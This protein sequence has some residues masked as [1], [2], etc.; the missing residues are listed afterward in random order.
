MRRDGDEVL[1]HW[2][3]IG[4]WW[5]RES[6]LE[7]RRFVDS[8][9][10][11]REEHNA[12][13]YRREARTLERLSQMMRVRDEKV[14]KAMGY[15]PEP[16][17]QSFKHDDVDPEPY[18]LLFAQSGCAFGRSTMAVQDIFS[19]AET[20]SYEATLLADPFS[21]VGAVEFAK[22]ARELER[23]P[24]IGAAFEM[25]EGGEIVLVAQTK[26]GYRSLSRLITACHQDEPRLYPLCTWERLER[27]CEDLL[28]LTGGDN[29]PINR[30]ITKDCVDDGEA[31]L[32]RFIGLYGAHKVFVQ[33]ER[34][35][36]PWE[37]RTNRIL[38]DLAESRKLTAV[39]GNGVTHHN[40]ADF[41]AQD[42]L[43]CIETLCGIEEIVG[44]KPL[45]TLG[46]PPIVERPRRALNAERYLR[47]ASQMREIFAD[48]P[49]LLNNTKRLSD[50]CDGHVLPTRTQLPQFDENEAGKLCS[51]VRE[52][53][54]GLPRWLS[55]STLPRKWQLE[56]E[57]KRIIDRGFAGHFLVAWDMCRWAKSQGIVFSGRGSVVDSAVAYCLGLSRI[58]AYEHDLHFDRFL[59]PEDDSKRPDID[60]D[61]EARR[62]DDVRNYLV[63]KYGP[64]HVATV[65]AIGTFNTRGIVREVG[66]VLGIPPDDLSY[67]AKRIH[68]SVSP[69]RIEAAIEAKPELRNSNIPRERFHLVFELAKVL[70]DIPRNL[71]AHSSGV[72]ISRAPIADTVPVVPSAVDGIQILQWDKRSAKHYFDKF[73]ILCLRG[74]D[75][76]SDAMD[77]IQAHTPDF[78]VFNLPLDDENVYRTMRTGELI[79]VP[80]SA[81]PAM[82]QAHIRIKTKNLKEA[83]LVQAG[84]RPGVGGAVKLNELILRKNGKKPVPDTHPLLQKILGNTY[85]L[86]VFQE[87]VDMLLQEFGGYTAGQAEEIREDIYKK[88]REKD[89]QRIHDEVL[90]QFLERGHSP[91]VAEQV[92]SLVAQFQGYGFAE[93]HALA[94]AEIS[95]RSIYCQQNYP[96]EYFAA[97]LDA[98][99]A[100]YYG[101]CTLVNEARNRGVV[102]LPPDVNA[103][104]LKYRVEDV[105]VD[106]KPR[107]ALPNKGIRVA[108]SEIMNVSKKLL[109]RIVEHRRGYPYTSFYNFV[110]RVHP[111]R[112][113]LEWLI[114]S[115]ALDD[116]HSNRRA[117][118]WA[119]PKA[120]RYANSVRKMNDTLPIFLPEPEM[121]TDIQDFNVHEK[122]VQ[123]RRLL[124]LNVKAHLMA[125]EREKVK[126]KGGITSAEASRLPSGEKAI[127][128]GNPIRLRFPPTESGKRVLFFDLEDESGLLNVTCF[129]ETYQRYGH[130]VICHKYVTL[131][132]EAQDRDG[133]IAFLASHIFPYHAEIYKHLREDESLPLPVAD[134]LVT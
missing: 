93:G 22:V 85:G 74:N 46:Q 31:Y 118:L 29:G 123:E 115:G 124:G 48:R 113:E 55:K 35:Y 87:Q 117:M 34:C 32:D 16:N 83:S 40:P 25:E 63:Q 50:L 120:L 103:S 47:S 30:F 70:Q 12:F 104:N 80:Q 45:R 7:Y 82:R 111:N 42:M 99:P 26:V 90:G 112:D 91:E 36:L 1:A 96:T 88:R 76:L 97:L 54:R 18:A 129:D 127:V 39:A 59:P 121:P 79:G 44:R 132:G 9:G 69:A 77:R 60:I 108:L 62:R 131:R 122:A 3:E 107:L 86:I 38:L 105:I 33:I 128:V 21:L 125:F 64:E 27:H 61:F 2:R 95:V 109:E 106:G 71:R 51:I 53:S 28:C 43:V 75:V 49:D 81:S 119:I 15:A 10:T 67:L 52:E 72:V 134:F 100:G 89:V 58:D 98:Q 13:Q 114:L 56:L 73:D 78:S 6:P 41:P 130:N 133:H 5:E 68:G 66:K 57:L 110:S 4:Q 84:I 19:Y 23:K 92:Y 102:I 126:S 11:I 20:Q 116:L 14:A 37:I 94:F 65:G 8:M 101:P 24:L 17:Y